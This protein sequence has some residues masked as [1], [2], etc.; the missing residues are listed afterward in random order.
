MTR[1]PARTPLV[2]PAGPRLPPLLADDLERSRRRGCLGDPSRRSGTD[3]EDAAA[4]GDAP[5]GSGADEAPAPAGDARAGDAPA[6]DA[7]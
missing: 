3:T 4:H 1:E 2:R 6:G 5:T 7:P